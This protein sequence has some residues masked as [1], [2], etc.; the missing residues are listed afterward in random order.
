MA[1]AGC[2]VAAAAS[3]AGAMMPLNGVDQQLPTLSPATP[4][5][6]P[7][8]SRYWRGRLTTGRASA[9]CGTRKPARW[10]EIWLA[11]RR[12]RRRRRRP[13]SFRWG[14]IELCRCGWRGDTYAPMV[15]KFQ[16]R[17]YC[18]PGVRGAFAICGLEKKLPATSQKISQLSRGRC[19]GPPHFLAGFLGSAG[20]G[21]PQRAPNR[22]ESPAQG[23]G[24][25]GSGVGLLAWT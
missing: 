24:G 18:P 7:L 11:T 2:V 6:A 1:L 14:D 10:T 5:A 16:L 22:R 19:G 17:N 23:A 20:T 4:R 12:W 3:A 15:S 13:G 21:T 9:R 25:L 8:E